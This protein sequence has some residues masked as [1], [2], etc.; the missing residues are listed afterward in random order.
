MGIVWNEGCILSPSLICLDM[1]NL[2]SQVQELEKAGI[3]MLHID[4]LDGRFS[5]SMPLG[6]ETVRQ[7]RE[8]TGLAFDVHLMAEKNDYFIDELLRIGVQ[9]IVFHVETEAHV[10]ATI[11][12]IKAHDVR[13]GVALKPATSLS[14]LDFVIEKCDTVLL[15]LINPGFAW[16]KAERQISYAGRKIRDLRRLIEARQ[17]D[18]LIEVDVRISHQNIKDYGASL[19]DIFVAGSTC[20][21][22]A[23]I[24]GSVS[25]LQQLRT[26]VLG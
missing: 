17:A 21:S 12:R 20:I 8:K 24:S 23:S 18:T 4:I 5:P 10:D 26:E 9:Q 1:C 2:A 22:P 7:L 11:N 16:N 15:M 6:L 13:A 19:V 14:V 25:A 3:G